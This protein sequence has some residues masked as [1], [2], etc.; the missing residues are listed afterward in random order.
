MKRTGGL[1]RTA[2][3][4]NLAIS[5]LGRIAVTNEGRVKNDASVLIG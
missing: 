4:M 5:Y 1:T 2:V 3:G